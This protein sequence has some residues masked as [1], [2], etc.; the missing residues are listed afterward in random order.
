MVAADDLL[1]KQ[2]ASLWWSHLFDGH[3]AEQQVGSLQLAV[4]MDVSLIDS[5]AQKTAALTQ[6]SAARQTVASLLDGGTFSQADANTVLAAFA[7]IQ[8]Q[9]NGR[10]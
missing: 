8:T 5:A 2:Y 4:G 6:L 3:S 9:V 7:D 10:P 1:A